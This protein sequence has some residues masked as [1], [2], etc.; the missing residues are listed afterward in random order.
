MAHC[1]PRLVQCLWLY[2]SYSLISDST[3]DLET[4]ITYFESRTNKQTNLEVIDV[5]SKVDSAHVFHQNVHLTSSISRNI[6]TQDLVPFQ[7]PYCHLRKKVWLY[8][9]NYHKNLR[10]K[11]WHF[12]I[13]NY[14]YCFCFAVPLSGVRV[15]HSVYCLLFLIPHTSC[16]QRQNALKKLVSNVTGQLM[17]CCLFLH[18]C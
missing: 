11:I 4:S 6:H 2:V 12:E 5:F 10:K 15:N 17:Y 1:D 3:L 8:W 7:N 18:F 16:T 9:Y 14:I 13:E